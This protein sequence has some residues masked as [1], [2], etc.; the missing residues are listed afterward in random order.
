MTK[1]T[2]EQFGDALRDQGVATEDVCFRCPLCGTIQSAQDLIDAGA[3]KNLDEVEKYL[4]FSCVGRLTHGKPPPKEKG[5]Q[6]GC[7][8]T[9]GGL[10]TFHKL[11]VVT[12]DGEK[13]PRFEVCTPE[14][15][16]AHKNRRVAV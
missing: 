16:Q 13:H 15:A 5:T 8:W 6:E 4:A 2:V 7:D 14:E 12:P 10:F 11:T 1:M 3:G 9:L